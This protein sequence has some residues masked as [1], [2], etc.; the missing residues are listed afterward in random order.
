MAVEHSFTKTILQILEED[1][2]SDGGE[3]FKNSPLLQYINIKTRSAVSGSKARGSFANLYAIYV[4]VE[5]YVGQGFHTHSSGDYSSYKGAVFSDLFRRQRELPFG[6]KLQNHALNS[7]LN[8]EFRKFFPTCE[9]VPI[10]RDLPTNRYWIN[11]PLLLI[12]ISNGVI[13]IATAI[14][15][16]I[17]AYIRAKQSAFEQFLQ[18]CERIQTFQSSDLAQVEVFVRGFLKPNVDARIFEIVS[19]AILK[20]YY[21]EKAIYWGWTPGDVHPEFLMLYKT[22]RTNAND[23][24]IDFIMRPLG[25]IFQVTETTDVRKYFLD[26]DKVQRFPITFVVKSEESSETLRNYIEAQARRL[27]GVDQIVQ[28]YMQSVE[29]LINIPILI[30]YLIEVSK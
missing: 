10:L 14:L 28:R 25:R 13:N 29:E 20:A 30:A 12:S 26:I 5:D 8:E 22:G 21:G 2:G 24:G 18:D 6:Q 27:Y 17:D 3:I 16:I 7:R 4:L 23:G 11:E 19:Y 15:R 1:F 9:Y